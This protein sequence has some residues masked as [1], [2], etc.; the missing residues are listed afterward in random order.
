[1]KYYT[2]DLKRILYEIERKF[3]DIDIIEFSLYSGPGD[4]KYILDLN[5]EDIEHEYKKY[6]I[7]S[8]P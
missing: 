7:S 2:V 6:I 4:F 8:I 3:N 5:F 1:M